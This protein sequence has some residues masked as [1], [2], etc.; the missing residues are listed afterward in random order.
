MG[1]ESTPAKACARRSGRITQ[2][3]NV[4]LHRRGPEGRWTEIPV[5]TRELSRY[6][7][8]VASPVKLELGDEVFLWWL[9]GMRDVHARVVYRAPDVTAHWVELGVEFLDSDDF[10]RIQF[11]PGKPGSASVPAGPKADCPR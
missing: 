11:P 6:G 5:E 1:S 2:H 10:W 7:C 4:M 3:L 8:L 9:E